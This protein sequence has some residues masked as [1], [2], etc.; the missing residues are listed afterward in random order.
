MADLL[1][2][3]ALRESRRKYRL[4]NEHK[5]READSSLSVFPKVIGKSGY[6]YFMVW[7]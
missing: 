6:Q 2:D 7:M 4:K 3:S 5:K 1:Q